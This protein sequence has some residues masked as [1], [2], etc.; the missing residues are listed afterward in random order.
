MAMRDKDVRQAVKQHLNT[1]HKGDCGTR[2][3]EEMCVWSGTVR[4]DIAVINGELAGFELKSNRDTLDRLPLQA[5]VYSRVFDRVTLVV[6][7]KHVK[8][9]LPLIPDWWSVFVASDT[10]GGIS[11]ITE[12]EGNL[13]PAPQAVLIAEFLKKEEAVA[14]LAEHGLDRGWRSKPIRLLHQRLAENLPLEMLK[15]GVR[16]TLKS[17]ENWLRQG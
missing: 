4:I 15:S 7:Q 2:V 8:K 16:K 13:N 14:L 3:V 9:S 5:D 17:R 6:G 12:R 11:L 10:Y 1:L